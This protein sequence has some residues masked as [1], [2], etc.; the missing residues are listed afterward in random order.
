MSEVLIQ[1]L[2]RATEGGEQW[3]EVGTPGQP[4]LQNSWANAGAGNTTCAFRKNVLGMVEL[5]GVLTNAAG[6]NAATAFVLPDGYRPKHS[7]GSS[8]SGSSTSAPRTSA[9]LKSTRTARSS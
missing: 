1:T 7:A 4:A 6:T 2:Q 9:S 8:R 3:R 5:R